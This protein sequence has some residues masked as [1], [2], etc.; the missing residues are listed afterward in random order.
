MC[1]NKKQRGKN[2][3]GIGK[4]LESCESEREGENE[5]RLWG[6]DYMQMANKTVNGNLKAG[7]FSL[8]L[9]SAGELALLVGR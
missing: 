4:T 3:T 6:R 5:A 2:F 9:C 8:H 1:V 7:R